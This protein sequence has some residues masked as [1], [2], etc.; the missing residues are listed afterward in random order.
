MVSIIGV[1]FKP[2]GKIYYFDPQ[3]IEV[4]RGDNV[5]VETSRG[6]EYGNVI[7]GVKEVEDA[8]VTKPLKGVLRIATEE[9]TKTYNDNKTREKEAYKIC[10][11]KIA[12]HGLEMK[13]IE[14][15]Y[16]F[17]QNKILFYFTADGRVDFRDGSAERIHFVFELC[18]FGITATGC[19]GISEQNTEEQCTHFFNHCKS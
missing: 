16:T 8:V 17:D 14:V 7:H 9:D 5:I 4:H 1:R 18:E 12:E 13:L 10:T 3:G 15:E 6:I 11:Q 19:Q 2:T